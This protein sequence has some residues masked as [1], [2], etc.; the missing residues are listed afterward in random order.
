MHNFHHV[1]KC[2]CTCSKHCGQVECS[3]ICSKTLHFLLFQ[4]HI[5]W[6]N[7]SFVISFFGV[8]VLCIITCIQCMKGSCDYWC[9]REDFPWFDIEWQLLHYSFYFKSKPFYHYFRFIVYFC[10]VSRMCL[11]LYI[12]YELYFLVPSLVFWNFT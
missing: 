12:C 8:Y 5:S 7:D 9:R 6:A 4:L 10:I 1:I 11:S 2:I 3:K